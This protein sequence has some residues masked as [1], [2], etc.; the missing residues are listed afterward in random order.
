MQK[1]EKVTKPE[2]QKTRKSE[3]SKVKK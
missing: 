3:K 2:N 1:S